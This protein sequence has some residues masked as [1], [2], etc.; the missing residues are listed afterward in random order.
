[1]NFWKTMSVFPFPDELHIKYLLNCCRLNFPDFYLN[2]GGFLPLGPTVGQGLKTT[3]KVIQTYSGFLVNFFSK[4]TTIP[5]SPRLILGDSVSQSFAI[6][7]IV[8]RNS[9]DLK[10]VTCVPAKII[11]WNLDLRKILGGTKIFLKSRFF[12]ISNTR[13]SLITYINNNW[14]TVNYFI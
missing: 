10:L 13:K 3:K 14:Y 11:Q 4:F 1:M 12:L 9:L 7:V 8:D 2:S 6:C 5:H